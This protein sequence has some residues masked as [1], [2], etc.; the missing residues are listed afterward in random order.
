MTCDLT[1]VQ[2]AEAAFCLF[3]LLSFPSHLFQ[4]PHTKLWRGSCLWAENWLPHSGRPMCGCWNKYLW[5]SHSQ[6]TVHWREGLCSVLDTDRGLC[7]RKARQFSI[8]KWRRGG[9]LNVSKPSEWMLSLWVRLICLRRGQVLEP[10][11]VLNDQ[12][13]LFQCSWFFM[14]PPEEEFQATGNL[15]V[16]Q[17]ILSY[18][19]CKCF[20]FQRPFP[21]EFPGYIPRSLFGMHPGTER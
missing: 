13:G 3:V 14:V 19:S 2:T 1:S 11:I 15:F 8:C 16:A 12:Q 18:L 7:S 4:R 6:V 20:L 5:V 9:Q 17:S 21:S 10:C